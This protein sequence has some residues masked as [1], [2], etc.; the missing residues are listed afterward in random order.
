LRS[1]GRSVRCETRSRRCSP[2]EGTSPS[3]PHPLPVRSRVSLAAAQRLQHIKR[4]CQQKDARIYAERGWNA[5]LAVESIDAMTSRHH[6]EH[7]PKYRHG[8]HC[9]KHCHD[10]DGWSHEPTAGSRAV[11][12]RSE[13]APGSRCRGPPVAALPRWGC[14]RY[15]SPGRMAGTAR[16]LRCWRTRTGR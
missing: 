10:G 7:S 3:D 4:P 1:S 8:V 11:V 15:P 6:A 13:P 9:R 12:R 16:K 5:L 14:P 2:V